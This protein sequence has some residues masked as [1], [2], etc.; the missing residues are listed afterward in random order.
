MGTFISRGVLRRPG[1]GTLAVYRN[2]KGLNLPISGPP[3]PGLDTAPQPRHVALLGADY[4]GM[5]PT[6]HV[7]VGDHVSRGQLVFEDKKT[8]GVRFTAPAEGKV[9]A[10]NR[11]D[12]RAFQSLVIQL[13]P[14]ELGG[15]AVACK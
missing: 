8:P 12:K 13:S 10:I 11:G 7:A 6:M 15:S 9:V 4:V 5:K 1:S 14:A 3:E 2:R